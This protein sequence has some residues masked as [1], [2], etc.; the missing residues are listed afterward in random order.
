MLTRII[1]L[2]LLSIEPTGKMVVRLPLV[3][4][5]IIIVC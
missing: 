2:K 3:D 5:P 4:D 1:D